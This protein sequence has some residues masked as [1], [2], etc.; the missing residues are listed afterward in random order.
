M[1]RGA[2]FACF[3]GGGAEYGAHFDGGG[4]NNVCKITTILYVNHEWDVHAHGGALELYDER[5]GC[6][7]S[8]APTAGRLVSFR[9]DTVLAKHDET[10]MPKDVADAL[11]KQGHW[12]DDYGKQGMPSAS[13]AP[14]QGAMR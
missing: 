9:A 14:T 2:D 3:P 11:K 5:A 12:K 6:W 8:V 10:Y 7:H 13:A 1:C 4:F